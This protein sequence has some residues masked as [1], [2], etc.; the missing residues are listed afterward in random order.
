MDKKAKQ[1]A[2]KAKRAQEVRTAPRRGW[3]LPWG[4]GHLTAAAARLQLVE[5]GLPSPHPPA[6][7]LP[8]HA[9]V[10]GAGARKPL[11]A[12]PAPPCR[13]LTPPLLPPSNPPCRPRPRP[14]SP[15]AP[16][17]ACARAMPACTTSPCASWWPRSPPAPS[18]W[19]AATPPSPSASRR[20]TRRQTGC[21]RGAC[22]CACSTGAREGGWRGG[23]AASAWR[24]AAGAGSERISAGC[25]LPAASPSCPALGPVRDAVAPVAAHCGLQPEAGGWA[26]AL[27]GPL[28][29][30]PLP[31]SA[32]A[33]CCHRTPPTAPGAALDQRRTSLPRACPRPAGLPP[34][35]RPGSSWWRPPLKTSPQSALRPR[36]WLPAA[37]TSSGPG[38]AGS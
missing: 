12:R 23:A 3:V 11:L 15:R 27:L 5:P 32:A 26:R 31:G 35:T 7:A 2:A 24:W 9:A 1:Q 16:A 34:T 6:P 20:R 21:W 14:S 29:V 37:S 10:A 4:E 28:R 8:T 36:S 30:G 38:R 19:A 33:A 22:C 17:P 18:W 25:V 13:Q